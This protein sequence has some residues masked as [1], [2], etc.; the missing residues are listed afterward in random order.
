MDSPHDRTAFHYWGDGETIDGVPPTDLTEVDL[1][2]FD[3]GQLRQIRDAEIVRYSGNKQKR[4]PLYSR[5]HRPAKMYT[6]LEPTDW[7][8]VQAERDAA[9]LE[10][11]LKAQAESEASAETPAANET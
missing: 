3:P 7:E 8:K 4:Y 10:D 5:S 1:S 9:L 6:A 11:A 2:R